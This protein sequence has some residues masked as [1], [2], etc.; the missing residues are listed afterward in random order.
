[1]EMSLHFLKKI[2]LGSFTS[3]FL[4]EKKYSLG[5]VNRVIAG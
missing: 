3:C 1:M 2:V 4:I 5:G